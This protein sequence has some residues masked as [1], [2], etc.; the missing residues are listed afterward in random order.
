MDRQSCFVENRLPSLDGL[1]AV[2]ICMVVIAHCSGKISESG[3][4][5]SLKRRIVQSIHLATVVSDD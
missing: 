2:S 1:R 5:R 3:G 4:D